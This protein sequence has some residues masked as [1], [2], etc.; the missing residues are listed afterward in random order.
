MIIYAQDPRL[1]DYV[2]KQLNIE[3][4]FRPDE[5]RTLANVAD[6]ARILCVVAYSGFRKHSCEMTIASESPL[7][8][9]RRFLRTAFQFPFIEWAYKR[10]TFVTTPGNHRAIRL[11]EWLGAHY[12]GRLRR[13]FGDEDGLVYGLLREECWSLNEKPIIRANLVHAA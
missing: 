7:W 3:P 2:N 11:N 9:T 10:V 8:C 1:V 6:D 5:V 4:P 12:E 13:W